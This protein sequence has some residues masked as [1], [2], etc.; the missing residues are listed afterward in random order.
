MSTQRCLLKVTGKWQLE[1]LPFFFYWLSTVSVKNIQPSTSQ[2]AELL[3]QVVK[4]GERVWVTFYKQITEN[5]RE[6][7][8]T[9]HNY[10]QK[11]IIRYFLSFEVVI[12]TYPYKGPSLPIAE[13]MMTLLAVSSHTY[14]NVYS[15][16]LPSK[17]RLF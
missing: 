9:K 3:Q 6:N 8:L 4:T 17:K 14:N 13:T 10:F 12:E 7:F 15:K 5:R 2:I 1:V 11:H 16:A